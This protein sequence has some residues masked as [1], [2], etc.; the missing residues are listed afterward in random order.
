MPRIEILAIIILAALTVD[1]AFAL[2]PQKSI[3]QFVHTAWTE[4]DGAPDDVRA[5]AQ[6]KDGY[7]WIGA[8]A[9]LFRFD[10][11]RFSA[12]DM[13]DPGFSGQVRVW[14]LLATRDGSLWVVFANGAISR[15]RDGKVTAFLQSDGLPHV[16]SLTQSPSGTLVAGTA[17]GIWRFTGQ[18]WENAGK[19]WNFPAKEAW[20]LYYDK[21]G[22]LWADTENQIV[23]LPA[24]Q[25]QF[26]VPGDP[27]G[28]TGTFAEAPDGQVWIADW[29]RSAHV[30]RRAGDRVPA[31]EVRVGAICLLFDRAGSLWIGSIGDGLRRVAFPKTIGGISV[32]QFGPEAEQF[33]ASDGLSTNYVHA[34][35][36]DREG[37]IWWGTRYGIDRFRDAA[38]IA[39]PIPHPEVAAAVLTCEDGNVWSYTLN[40]TGLLRIDSQGV[41]LAARSDGVSG[42]C[43]NGGGI[44]F[45]TSRSV[46]RYANGRLVRMPLLLEPG[47]HSITSVAIDRGDGIWLLDREKGVV[48]MA[49]GAIAKVLENT[50]IVEDWG[51]L[52]TD[53]RDRVWRGQGF[54]V[55]VYD[56][57]KIQ[58]FGA[59]ENAP[60]GPFFA[61]AEDHSGSIWAAADGGLRKFEEGGLRV[62]SPQSGFPAKS[63]Y[64]IAEDDDRQFWM[65]TDVGVLRIPV[66]DLD[67]SIAD[68]NYRVHFQT[69]DSLDGLPGN[70]RR[71]FPMPVVSRGSDGRIWFAAT[72]G[73]AFVDPRRLPKNP[74]PPLVLVNSVV[75]ANKES[76]AIEG[77]AFSHRQNDLEIRYTALSLSIPER[78]RFRYKLEGKDT[79]WVD[80]GTRRQAYYTGLAPKTYR[81][82]VIASNDSGVWNEA[83]A[84]WTFS[85]TPAFYQTYWFDALCVLTGA[86]LLTGAYRL[87][88]RQ[89]AT[90]MTTRF[91]ER[92]AERTSLAL[93]LHDTL[94]QSIQGSKIVADYVLSQDAD[95]D[96]LRDAMKRVSAWLTRA[97]DECRSA[98][99]SLRTSSTETNDLA[100][101]LRRAAEECQFEPR[102]QF[103]LH[104]EGTTREMHPIVRDEVSRIGYEAI[105]NAC[106]HSEGNELAVELSYAGELILRVRDNGKGIDPSLAQKGKDG[107]FGLTG[108]QERAARLRGRLTISSP[109][110]TG[111]GTEVELVVSDRIAFLRPVSPGRRW[112]G[113][114]LAVSTRNDRHA[115][116]GR[117]N[118]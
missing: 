99:N 68:P 54:R 55:S 18:R 66:E 65:E 43:T 41:H 60:S 17:D 8:A 97:I 28:R 42:V 38:F 59:K 32:A 72:R 101:G 46:N 118:L 112:F 63:V 110:K 102:F 25:S 67:R 23:Y 24:G 33:T 37:N 20:E 91:N 50:G 4:R 30:V 84:A 103:H 11:T 56:H 34:V 109:S 53:S 108:M 27:S 3:T 40:P 22:T 64:G 75:A 111:V 81:F 48:R 117:R 62:P 9:G 94:L 90:A 83:G 14:H 51:V 78:V 88:V 21:A 73:I 96:A 89:L 77:M 52:Y 44:L 85:V 86:L 45:A 113:R 29:A 47:L 114:I 15:L 5:L 36:E 82:R 74:V 71:T 87:R 49:N 106:S 39:V 2:D 107:H 116:N 61:F 13:R 115:A 79:D 104:V 7:L 69:F 10:G 58:T 19:E 105:R 95:P 16:Y 98:V 31:T 100:E 76:P 80:V 6:T 57:G 93:D 70:A 92:M 12:F 26:V 1:S 35:L